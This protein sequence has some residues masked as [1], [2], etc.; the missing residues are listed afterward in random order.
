MKRFGKVIVTVLLFTIIAGVFVSCSRSGKLIPLTDEEGNYSEEAFAKN[1][2]SAKYGGLKLF[3]NG[4]TKYKIV[5]PKDAEKVLTDAVCDL[6]TALKEISGA[7]FAYVDDTATPSGREICVGATNRAFSKAPMVTDSAAY[8]LFSEDDRIFI[9]AN[10]CYGAS[11]GVY[12]FLEDYLGVMYMDET[13]TYYP[14]LKKAVLPALDDFQTPAF[15]VRDVYSSVTKVERY[16]HQLRLTGGEVF[17]PDGCHNSLR[18]VPLSVYFDEHPEYYAFIGGQRRN[19]D[20]MFQHTQLCWSNPEVINL[21]A[22]TAEERIDDNKKTGNARVIYFD[23]SQEDSMN[24]CECSNCKALETQYGSPIAPILLAVNEIARRFPD[25]YFSTLAYHYGATTPT[26]LVPEDNVLIK[27]CFMG[28]FGAND[29]SAPVGQAESKI[30][31][32][33]YDEITGWGKITSNIYVWDYVTNYFN[34]LLPFPCF[35]SLQGNYQLMRDCNVRGVFSLGAYNERG[36]SD[37]MKSYLISKLMWNPDCD[38]DFLMNKYMT[39]Y[40]KEAAPYI[41]QLYALQ[42]ENLNRALWVYDFPFTHMNDYLSR[43][44]V[45]AYSALL[46]QAFNAVQGD[47]LISKRLRFEQLSLT[48]AEN[49]LNYGDP[50]ETGARL[51]ELCKEFGIERFNEM[52][53]DVP[54]FS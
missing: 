46:T 2:A 28:S 15:E 3:S 45:E 48:Y 8:Y 51:N 29:L 19:S 20:Y 34:Y 25:A 33:Q 24:R 38:Y 47:E 30:S 10:S 18:F 31:R 32:K 36:S 26:G 41:K 52:S 42:R 13:Y 1:L 23:F 43:Q 50:K 22:K 4:K 53:T 17:D 12:G 44:A 11:N 35:Q 37:C 7:E 9:Y 16:R 5:Y 6:A 27:Y 40:Y 14:E 54:N 49:K 21:L 39:L